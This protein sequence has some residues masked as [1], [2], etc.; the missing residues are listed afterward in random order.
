MQESGDWTA[1]ANAGV[2]ND[3]TTVGAS[4]SANTDG[5]VVGGNASV[6]H[7]GSGNSGSVVSAGGSYRAED[8]SVQGTGSVT[9]RE[10]TSG[11]QGSVTVGFG[12]GRSNSVAVSAGHTT[13]RGNDSTTDTNQARAD[14]DLGDD[15]ASL[16]YRGQR[17]NGSDESSSDT[18]TADYAHQ[19]TLRE[20]EEGQARETL[21]L[22]GG[23]TVGLNSGEG[24]NTGEGRAGVT[25]RDA[26]DDLTV[27]GSLAGGRYEASQIQSGTGGGSLLDETATHGAMLD[28]EVEIERGDQRYSGRF[29]LGQTGGTTGVGVGVGVSDGAYDAS[30]RAGIVANGDAVGGSAEFDLG[31][32]LSNTLNVGFGGSVGGRSDEEGVDWTAFAETE[33]ALPSNLTL[34]IRTTV[35]GSEDNTM[36]VPETILERDGQ[37]NIGL[38]GVISTDGSGGGG[39][40]RATY[41][42]WGL[43]AFASAGD[44]SGMPS[45]TAGRIP[46]MGDDVLAHEGVNVAAGLQWDLLSLVR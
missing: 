2:S 33:M 13:Q 12:E 15:Q 26:D 46:G 36:I 3:T 28:A 37:F 11:G 39:S 22:S 1:A 27:E 6:A 17:V 4:A 42:P 5:T 19:L 43:S 34:T 24:Q 7:H 9:A 41:Q 8:L 23:A 35:T 40:I 14:V 20:N 25:Y 32:E 31:V 29:T 16:S 30:A 10:D 44:V 21:R 38:G 18:V 45:G